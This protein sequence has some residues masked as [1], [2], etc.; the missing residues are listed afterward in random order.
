MFNLLS[1]SRTTDLSEFS[2]LLWQ[3][4]IAHRLQEHGDQQLLLIADPKHAVSALQLFKDWQQG[5]VKPAADD[6]TS[7]SDLF[8]TGEFTNGLLRAFLKAPFTLILALVC[9]A[10]L[11]LA[12]LDRPTDLTW[13]LLYPDFSY[14]TRTIVLERVLQ[15]FSVV[16]FFKMLSPIL[17]HGGLIHLAFNMMWLWELGSRIEKFQ[18]T[19]TMLMTVIVLGLISNTIQY[20]YGGGNNFGG[21]SGVVYGLFAY[22]W[23]WQLFDPRTEMGLPG[24]L[25]IFMLLS[26]VIMTML[27]LSMIA[28]AAHVGGFLAGILYGAIT[29]TIRRIKRALPST[30][31]PRD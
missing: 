8:S 20:L 29:A 15:N 12:P 26:L 19:L 1:V 2:H 18:S 31:P 16:Q 30:E 17:L 3:R 13:Q 22:I 10:L 4:R 6:N 5:A 24:S 27:G 25:I 9:I 14:G 21:M 28:N 7:A 23:M 11:F